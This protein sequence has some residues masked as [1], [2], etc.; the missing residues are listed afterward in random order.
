MQ[1]GGRGR[2][3][4]AESRIARWI[5]E[6]AVRTV[7]PGE[8]VRGLAERLRK[9]GITLGRLWVGAD[10]LHP[11]IGARTV[12]WSRGRGIEATGFGRS[13]RRDLDSPQWRATPLRVV[14]SERLSE[15]RRR[16]ATDY[17]KG[18]FAL[19]DSFLD[20][21]LTDYLACAVR[22][23]EGTVVGDSAV[24]VATFASDGPGG[25]S[26]REIEILSATVRP[27]ALAW[28]SILLLDA[29]RA[30]TGTYLGAD[31][32]QRVLSGS[33]ARGQVETIRAAIW[34][35]DLEGFT[36]LSDTLPKER[37]MALLNTYAGTV[38]DTIAGFGGEVL[39]LMGDGVLA[40][41]P[42]EAETD[43]CRRALD[44]AIAALH[45]VDRTSAERRAVGEPITRM[46]VGLHLGEVLYG[47]IG[48]A[49]RL[50]FTVLGPAVNEASR[51]ERMCRT[52]ER[53][54]VASAAFAEGSGE[55]GRR[56]TSLGRFTLRGVARPQELFT[57]DPGR[58]LGLPSGA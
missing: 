2:D 51:L 16:L 10:I 13:E 30:V 44:A 38:L 8:L 4:T 43:A 20:A 11:T 48:S 26:E 32:A 35:S 58:S 28:R 18:E 40:I 52:V 33:I 22:F 41:F 21:G 39:K 7:E 5:A 6:A 24:M 23:P 15:F 37:L 29:L 12:S 56:L 53:P 34:F 17:R 55:A 3:G 47:N 46:F 9:E 54:I 1:T 50:D 42:L 27:L 14:L 19:L 36:T 31:A 45:A 57:L 25:F 49:D